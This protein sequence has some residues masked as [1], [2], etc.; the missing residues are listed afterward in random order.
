[1]TNPDALYERFSG[2]EISL[3]DFSHELVALR[4]VDPEAAQE[5]EALLRT[6]YQ[7]GSISKEDFNRLLFF[8]I[9]LLDPHGGSSCSL[10]QV[11]RVGFGS[12]NY[13]QTS[14][15]AMVEVSIA[16]VSFQSSSANSS[17]VSSM[18]S[19]KRSRSR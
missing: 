16:R 14:S 17:R 18:N 3:E 12:G 6:D 15:S 1:M 11:Y 4:L 7:A 8:G 10:S 19:C 13:S 5:V 2:G 9:D